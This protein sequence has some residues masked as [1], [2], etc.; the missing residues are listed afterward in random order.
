MYSCPQRPKPIVPYLEIELLI[1]HLLGLY[2]PVLQKRTSTL[3]VFNSMLLQN[4]C[5][6]FWNM[7]SFDPFKLCCLCCFQTIFPERF[8]YYSGAFWVPRGFLSHGR[9]PVSDRRNRRIFFRALP[10]TYLTMHFYSSINDSSSIAREHKYRSLL[11]RV[12][13]TKVRLKT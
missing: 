6:S 9:W 13:L 8:L 4:I 1:T 3:A 2:P 12:L 5:I 11:V 7:V 10:K